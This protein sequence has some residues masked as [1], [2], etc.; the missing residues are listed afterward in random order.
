MF[1]PAWE[2]CGSVFCAGAPFYSGV[3]ES[4]AKKARQARGS[5]EPVFAKPRSLSPHQRKTHLNLAAD[6]QTSL[7]KHAGLSFARV[8]PF[9]VVLKSNQEE[10]RSKKAR[11]ARGSA[12]P[13][14]AKPRL[15]PH[16]RKTHLNLAADVQTSLR[17]MWVC[18]LRGRPLL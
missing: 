10:S 15:S 8:P 2:T 9:I 17:N 3:E 13:V 1:K 14:F 11:Q 16:Q 5:A 18:L 7:R 4:R 12:E 6:V